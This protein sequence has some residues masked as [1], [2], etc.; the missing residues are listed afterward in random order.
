[1]LRQKARPYLF[2]NSLAPAVVG[3][4]LAALDLLEASTELR[5][6][7]EQNTAIFRKAISQVAPS[8]Q[9]CCPLFECFCSMIREYWLIGPAEVIAVQHADP[10]LWRS[11]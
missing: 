7:L 10:L 2:S 8:C 3:A 5:D 9:P 6:R 4:S 1:M 11:N